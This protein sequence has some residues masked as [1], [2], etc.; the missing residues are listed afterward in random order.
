MMPT[1]EAACRRTSTTSALVAFVSALGLVYLFH[2][3]RGPVAIWMGLAF[4]LLAAMV[5]FFIVQRITRNR[6]RQKTPVL[7]A[8]RGAS[9]A[10]L[11]FTITLSAHVC[12]E[13]KEG[14]FWISLLFTLAMGLYICGWIVAIIGALVGSYC[15]RAYFTNPQANAR[16]SGSIEKRIKKNS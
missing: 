15:E 12:I 2:Q 11:T 14:G 9:A 16:A 4:G 6:C 1:L 13:H 5:A 3:N 10:L 7:G 8:L